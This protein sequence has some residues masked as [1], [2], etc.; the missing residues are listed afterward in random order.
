MRDEQIIEILEKI[1]KK[2]IFTDCLQC[3]FNIE[4]DKSR[5]CQIA[6]LGMYVFSDCPAD[7]NLDKLKEILNA[8]N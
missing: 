5:E 6:L 4:F 1:K 3:P 7:W 2:C 8:P